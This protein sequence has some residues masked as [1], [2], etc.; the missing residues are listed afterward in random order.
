VLLGVP[1]LLTGCGQ[2]PP[3]SVAKPSPMPPAAEAA[4]PPKVGVFSIEAAQRW[5]TYQYLSNDP[6]R[7]PMMIELFVAAGGHT[8]DPSANALGV[9]GVFLGRLGAAHPGVLDDWA[10]AAAGLSIESRLVFG[11]GVW[12]ADPVGAGPRLERIAEG[13]DD[14]DAPALLE[15]IGQ[16]PPDLAMLTP[17][18]PGVLD[19]WWAA[20][21]AEGD[22]AWVDRVL[23]VIPAPG[24]SFE[25]SGLS[26]PARLEVAKAAAWSLTSNAAQHP[27]VL[28][29]L[30]QRLDEAGGDWPAI[31][32]IVETAA[33]TATDSPPVLP[34]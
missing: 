16:Q 25:D 5:I 9:I 6:E 29:H 26:D 32:R 18:S 27:R 22:T 24:V 8:V 30:R 20:F 21:M 13:M 28:G 19:F 23:A 17:D 1:L 14:A 4:G 7:A 31:A 12:D 2:E 15:L 34:D 10:E 33:K 3:Q 11:Y